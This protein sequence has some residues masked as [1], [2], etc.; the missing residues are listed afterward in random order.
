MKFVLYDDVTNEWSN[1]VDKD[2]YVS[3]DSC[4]ESSF[5]YLHEDL[6]LDNTFSNP[7]FQLEEVKHIIIDMYNPI[8]TCTLTFNDDNEFKGISTFLN[9]L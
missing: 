1:Q 8:D 7:L 3:I 4:D 6:Q 9:L 2:P 5:E